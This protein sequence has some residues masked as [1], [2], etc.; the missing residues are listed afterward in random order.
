MGAHR[1]WL[2]VTVEGRNSAQQYMGGTC[3]PLLHHGCL[4]GRV[5]SSR[6]LPPPPG[7][8]LQACTIRLAA[9]CASAATATLLRI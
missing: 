5:C 7:C 4:H 2:H 6:V 9:L 1:R 3:C 8:A